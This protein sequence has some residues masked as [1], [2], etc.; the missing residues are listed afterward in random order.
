MILVVGA[1][2]L[3]G[4]LI[5]R[6]LL[7]QGH[8]VRILVRENS[9]SEQLAPQGRATSAASLIEAGAQLVTGDLKEP[10]SLAAG[11]PAPGFWWSRAR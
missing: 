9:P 5:T 7:D 2:G 10:A 4:G 1:T 8:A 11:C 3:L 6:Q